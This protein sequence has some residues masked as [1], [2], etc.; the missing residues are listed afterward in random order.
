MS[1]GTNNKLLSGP[2]QIRKRAG[3]GLSL[4][5]GRGQNGRGIDEVLQEIAAQVCIKMYMDIMLQLM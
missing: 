3:K 4:T 5:R 2:R 1:V